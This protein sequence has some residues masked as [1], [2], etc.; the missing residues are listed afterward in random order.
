MT[1]IE[2]V[3]SIFAAMWVDLSRPDNFSEK[4][5]LLA[6]YTSLSTLESIIR[7]N[8]VW[9]S[10]P[11][12]MNDMEELRFGLLEAEKAFHQ[13]EGIRQACDTKQYDALRQA[14]DQQL[15]TLA[16]E[17][18]LDVYVMCFSE[19]NISDYD[20]MLSMWRGYGA[21]GNGAA[22]VFDTQKVPINMNSPLLLEKVDYKT[23]EERLKW[24]DAKLNQFADL[25]K[26]SAIQIPMF[27][28]PIHLLI[29][30]FQ[31]FA[32]SSKHNGFDEE[33]EWR[34]IYIKDRDRENKMEKFFHYLIQSDRVEPKLK[35][36]VG[37]IPGMEMDLKLTD[38]V[39]RIILGPGVSS[40]MTLATVKRMLTLVGNKE[41]ASKVYGSTTPYRVK[42]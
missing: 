38:V 7:S 11:L 10:N 41:L 28:I 26:N 29:Q 24:I 8:E 40:G 31:L 36:K 14:F 17:H 22:I 4:L 15:S 3:H 1:E 9:L 39:E 6:H 20:G 19:H 42:V 25:I 33:R 23:T 37:Q 21:N 34:M 13:H 16:N 18:A 2:R 30:R 32:L 35:F 5:P 27:Y 12:F